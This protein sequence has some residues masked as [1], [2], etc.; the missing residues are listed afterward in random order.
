MGTDLTTLNVLRIR[1]GSLEDIMT[2]YLETDPE[3][4]F[5]DDLKPWEGKCTLMT[6]AE[7]GKEYYEL[8]FTYTVGNISTFEI[9]L[10]MTAGKS[11]VVFGLD[12]YEI[13]PEGSPHLEQE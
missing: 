9:E 1:N 6:D 8:T 13:A 7:T 12:G 2:N 3:T 10:E 5:R 4:G 11:G